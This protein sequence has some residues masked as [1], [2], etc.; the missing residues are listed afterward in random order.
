M[1]SIKRPK[2][3]PTYYKEYLDVFEKKNANLLPQYRPYDCLIDLQ[4]STQP[5]F[6]PIYNLFQNKLV[7]LREYLDENLAK[8]FIQQ[9]KSPTGVPIFFVKK[10]DG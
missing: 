5:P 9:S 1:E 6:G 7:A 2:A 4:E 10:K 8:K 3:L